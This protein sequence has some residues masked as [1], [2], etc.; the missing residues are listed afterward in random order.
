MRILGIERRRSRA[1]GV[2]ASLLVLAAACTSP[3]EGLDDGTELAAGD[4]HGNG[5]GTEQPPPDAG[6]VDAAPSTPDAG[7]DAAVAARVPS[8]VPGKVVTYAYGI[9]NSSYAAGYH[10]GDDYATPTG[11]SILA[12]RGG[13]IQ[14]SNDSGGAYGKWMGLMADNGRVYVYCHLSTRTA[15]AGAV[16]QAGEVLGKTGAT[17]NVTGPHLHFEDHPPGPFK[18]GMQR[19]PAW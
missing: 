14:W 7:A 4:D 1:W 13:T 9:K 2:S 3:P 10:T 6:A 15:Q 17:G 5:T 12:V 18:Y 16:V 11:S 8:P 19:K